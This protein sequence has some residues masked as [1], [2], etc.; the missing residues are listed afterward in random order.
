MS[1]LIW[2]HARVATMDG[3]APY[4]LIDDGAIA[5]TGNRIAWVG[6]FRDVPAGLSPPPEIH[7]AE[8]RCITPGLIDP[9]THVV[10]AGNRANEFEQR[11]LGATYEDIAAEGGGILSTVRATRAAGIDALTNAAKT[12]IA[13]LCAEGVTT[14]EIKS[15][16]GLDRDTELEMLRAARYLGRVLP[17]TVRTTYLG[18]H[19]VPPEFKGRADDYVAFVCDEMIPAVAREGLADAVDAFCERIA[20]SPEQTARVFDAA[21]KLGL[22]VKLHADQLT[23]CGGAALAARYRALSA[24][25]LEH[26]SDAGVAALA[27]SGTVATL[28]PGAYYFLR[29]T[30]LPP[31]ASLRR[32][33]VPIALATDCN[34]GTSPT[35]SLL[36]MLNMACTLFGLTPEEALAGVT[37][38][39][40][41]A[42]GLDGEIG[43]LTPGKAADLAVWDVGH[44]AELAYA[45]GTNPCWATYKSG[46]EAFRAGALRRE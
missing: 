15:G 4:G 27:A 10:Y 37:R 26:A 5:I 23:D 9:H 25:H 42:L 38:N 22:P 1:D 24:D 46:R 45:F 33:R 20:F 35:T 43:T 44:P 16:Y 17:V 11:L 41:R 36:L 39:A 29:E 2:T 19:T 12:R 6:S 3:P 21:T 30:H 14:V 32:H 8:G 7:D 13:R 28:L 34:P 18:A 31:I 40:A